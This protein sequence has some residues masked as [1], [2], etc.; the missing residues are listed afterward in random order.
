[1]VKVNGSK[2]LWTNIKS[3]GIIRIDDTTIREGFGKKTEFEGKRVLEKTDLKFQG[4]GGWRWGLG[5]RE[6]GGVGKFPRDLR[7]VSWKSPGGPT[8][9]LKTDILKRK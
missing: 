5:G 9:K 2:D 8:I 3:H 7:E 6:V 4:Q 1:M